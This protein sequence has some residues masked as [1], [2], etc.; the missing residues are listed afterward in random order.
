[1]A[2][3]ISALGGAAIAAIVAVL[4]FV[5]ERRSSR[6]AELREHFSAALADV[7]RWAEVPYRVR[8]RTPGH[9]HDVVALIHSLQ[10]CLLMHESW[11]RLESPQVHE[12]YVRLT[13]TLRGQCAPVIQQA[14]ES[15]PLPPGAAMNLGE[16]VSIDLAAAVDDYLSTVRSHLAGYAWRIWR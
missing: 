9:E 11:L 13:S 7:Y 10:E 14:W 12:A 2:P 6:S 3:L 16:A 1:M 4:L 5:V 15:D 8:R